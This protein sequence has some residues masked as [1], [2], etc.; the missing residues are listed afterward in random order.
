M[1]RRRRPRDPG[2]TTRRDAGDIEE[3]WSEGP[4]TFADGADP[5]SRRRGKVTQG[6]DHRTDSRDLRHA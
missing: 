3:I 6:V 5:Q 1:G 2:D 4:L